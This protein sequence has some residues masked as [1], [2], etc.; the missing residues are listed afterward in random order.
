MFLWC[1]QQVYIESNVQTTIVSFRLNNTI[2]SKNRYNIPY[3]LMFKRWKNKKPKYYGY[4]SLSVILYAL[5]SGENTIILPLSKPLTFEPTKKC[6]YD[7]YNFV[8]IRC[9]VFSICSYS[10]SSLAAAILNEICKCTE[11]QATIH[12]AYRNV[13]HIVVSILLYNWAYESR[14][15]FSQIKYQLHLNRRNKTQPTST[16]IKRRS[17]KKM[18]KV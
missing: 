14:E 1:G 15:N 7:K 4:K 2:H 5:P 11:M 8:F 13:L 10:Q 12:S 18:L 17:K 6:H 9:W 16:R 3:K